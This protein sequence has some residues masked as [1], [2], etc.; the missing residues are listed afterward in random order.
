MREEK[1][2]NGLCSCKHYLHALSLHNS[3]LLILHR[4]SGPLMWHSAAPREDVFPPR[5]GTE[6]ISPSPVNLLLFPREELKEN[7]WRERTLLLQFFK[8]KL[9]SDSSAEETFTAKTHRISRSGVFLF[10]N[11][12]REEHS[13]CQRL[14]ANAIHI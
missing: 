12:A 1:Q 7:P 11:I 6:K 8:N 10:F 5:T 13:M 3:L 4:A 2:A 14:K 9:K